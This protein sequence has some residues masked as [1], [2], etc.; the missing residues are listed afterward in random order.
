MKNFGKNLS[1]V[2]MLAAAAACT[3]DN[4]STGNGDGN[5]SAFV[6]ATSVKDAD[7]TANVLL[8]SP[9]LENGTVSAV[10]NGLV[11]DGATE[12]VFY[13]DKYLYALTY[14]QGNAGTTRSYV[15]GEDDQMTARSA[16][17][18][19][20]RF[21]SF[22][23]YGKYILSASTGDGLA[24]YAD[25]NGNLPKMILMTYLD[26]EAETAKQSDSKD[27]D[28]YMA[29]NFLGN[30]EY[31]M[32]SGF[33]ESDGKLY[34]AAVGMGLSAYG[35]AVDGGKYIRD[36]Y[37]DLVKTES[38]GT[39][40][41]SYVKGELPGTQYPNECWV[42]VFDDEYLGGR[43]LIKTDKISYACGRYKSQYYQSIWAA[44]NGDIYVFSP[45]VAKTSTDSRQQT[46]LDAGVVRIKAGTSEFDP[47]YYYSIEAQSGGK[48]FLRC[49][50]AGGSYFLIRMYD[51]PFSENGYVANQ[52]A[53]FNGDTGEL[54][55]V[56]GLP[57]ADTISDFAKTPYVSGGYVY[58]PVVTDSGCAIYKINTASASATK[59]VVLEVDS[60]TALGFLA[61]QN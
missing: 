46:M 57:D 7:K 13:K 56:T 10:N 22:G 4:Y 25:V 6:F 58:M 5:G 12:W 1:I 48:S 38:G 19:V 44:D 14:N 8:T 29:E 51:R 53:I 11:N 17:Y 40:G 20:S 18:K 59:G 23:K 45:S 49:W 33:E 61:A 37:S 47:D 32:L 26:V 21:T 27:K 39:G 34:S 55:F 52:L 43:K 30:G 3:D 42:A 35:S 50:H 15:L 9:G 28:A 16:E 2:F 36:G 54:T 41:G 60:V 24:E 31:V